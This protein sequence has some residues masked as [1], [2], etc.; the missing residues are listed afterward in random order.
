MAYTR[1]L[2]NAHVGGRYDEASERYMGGRRLVAA[3]SRAH[4]RAPTAAWPRVVRRHRPARYTRLEGRP[5]R[6]VSLVD[7]SLSSS[8]LSH[9][10]VTRVD[11]R[12]TPGAATE[13]VTPLFFPEK[14]GDLLLVA[15]SAVS[16]LISSSQ[17]LTTF[18]L[19]SLY[20]FLL[21]SPPSRVSPHTF[22]TCP[23]SF[24]HYSL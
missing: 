13:G 18:F 8:S 7:S 9:S 3:V 10:G 12:V 15:S 20:R 11:W 24:L 17:K 22:F 5:R 21:L 1:Q 16:P 6:R 2:V 23:T 14:P 19:S 4:R